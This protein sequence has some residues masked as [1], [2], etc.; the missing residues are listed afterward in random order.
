MGGVFFHF[1]RLNAAAAAVAAGSIVTHLTEPR[2]DALK[3]A[4]AGFTVSLRVFRLKLKS[5]LHTYSSNFNTKT[6]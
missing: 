1:R 2:Q 4:A 6:L 3:C 5:Q